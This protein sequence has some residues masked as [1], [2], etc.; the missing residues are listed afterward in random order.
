MTPHISS[1]TQFTLHQLATKHLV[2]GL[3]PTVCLEV[4]GL[5]ETLE[6]FSHNFTSK[7]QSDSDWYEESVVHQSQQLADELEC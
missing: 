1:D 5:E 6:S 4:S 7:P 2:F 3:D